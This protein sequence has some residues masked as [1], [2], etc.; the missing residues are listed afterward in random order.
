MSFNPQYSLW[1]RD[2]LSSSEGALYDNSGEFE[3]VGGV[4]KL[5]PLNFASGIYAFNAPWDHLTGWNV[6]NT[7]DSYSILEED[8]I[9]YT[10]LSS[11]NG[12]I[13]SL[14][15]TAFYTSGSSSTIIYDF[16]TAALPDQL[17]IELD[18]RSLTSPN[19][20]GEFLET[21]SAYHGIVLNDGSKQ[22]FIEV[23][24]EGLKVY[25]I[26][27]AILPGNYTDGLRKV[28]IVKKT[29]DIVLMSYYY[30]LFS[31]SKR[32]HPIGQVLDNQNGN[33]RF[34]ERIQ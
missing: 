33:F 7:L 4:S 6:E 16:Q 19:Y 14:Y 25:G 17:T 9:L 3:I 20:S 12:N 31:Y 29:N 34:V 27:G 22:S 23:H 32:I 24:P 30:E 8:F 26:S 5:I 11:E 28:R 15:N 21:G 1:S 18:V 2:T 13:G 10:G